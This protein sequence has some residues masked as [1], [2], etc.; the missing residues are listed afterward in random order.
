MKP[1]VAVLGASTNPERYSYKAVKMLQQYEYPAFPVHPA[2]RPIDGVPCF[3]SLDE[4][5][6]KIDTITIY[7]G[8][9]NSTPIIDGI[10]R[11]HPR[12]VILNPGAESEE[13][14]RRCEEAGIEVMEACTLVLLSTEQF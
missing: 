8:P 7:L 2:R 12:R 10:L 5:G 9:A 1:N 11:A 13:L 14:R 3:G 4:I 6:E